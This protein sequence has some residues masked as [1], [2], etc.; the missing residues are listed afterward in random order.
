MTDYVSFD[1]ARPVRKIAIL[2]A[3]FLGDLLCATPAFRALR[4][5]FPAAEITLIGLPWAADLAARLPAID[6][7]E[8]FPGYPG[9]VEVEYCAERTS[10]FL[11]ESRRYGYDL[12]IQMHG[13]GTS[14]NGFVAALG[15]R[16]SLGYTLAGD[17]RLMC[18]AL[19]REDQHEVLRW[20]RLV[21]M[22]D[23]PVPKHFNPED[24]ALDFPLRSADLRRARE[25]LFVDPPFP[26]VALH[27]GAKAKERRWPAERFGALADALIEQL[28]AAVF[29]T[30]SMRERS[31]TASV[32]RAMHHPA[33]ELAGDTDLG[34]FAAT[35]ARADLLVTNDT[36]AA[37]LAVAVGT[38]S[39]VLFGPG[40]PA[41]WGPLDRLRHRVIDAWE[42]AGYAGV[43]A[44]ALQRLP[45]ET[46]L[47]ECLN[48]LE[49]I[50]P[51]PARPA[52]KE[53]NA[54][55]EHSD[56]ARP[57]ELSYQPGPDRT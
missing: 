47:N 2:R 26:L 28:G 9:I 56:V 18:S 37:H 24:T 22:L 1:A 35:L 52:R 44:S 20:L 12:A 39:V 6:R 30:G 15:A 13:S 7:F 10:A 54:T 17:T 51:R 19:Y 29:L 41:E 4:R 53:S 36:G 33:L 5:R 31:L 40:R 3:L 57:R 45:V 14:S 55:L 25:L 46:V 27:A 43:G 16:Q 11:A 42:L 49:H 21:G 23:N 50:Q 32:R 48:L 8:P 38:P 34:T